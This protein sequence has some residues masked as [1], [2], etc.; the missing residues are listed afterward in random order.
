MPRRPDLAQH[1][2]IELGLELARLRTP[3]HFIPLTTHPFMST[4]YQG[5]AAASSDHIATNND[6]PSY[7]PFNEVEPSRSGRRKWLMVRCVNRVGTS[8]SRK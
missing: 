5:V 3:F 4:Y 1:S 6:N 7:N 2:N 8:L